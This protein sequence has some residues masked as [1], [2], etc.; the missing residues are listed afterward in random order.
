MYKQM[1]SAFGIETDEEW[2]EVQRT[3]IALKQ[4]RLVRSDKKET[5]DR[6]EILAAVKLHRDN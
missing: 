1:S 3:I 6:E 5:K 2:G 4:K